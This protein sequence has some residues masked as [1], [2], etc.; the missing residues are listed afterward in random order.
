MFLSILVPGP[1]NPKAKVDVFLQPL[2]DELNHLWAYGVQ[3]Y[4]TSKKQN[5]QMRAV[6]LWTIN[7]FPAYSM[8]SGWRTMGQKTCPY[9]GEDSDA[10]YLP[11]SGKQSWFDNHRKFLP[12]DHPYHRSRYGFKKGET[13]TKYFRGVRSGDEILEELNQYGLKKV[14]EV[15]AERINGYIFKELWLV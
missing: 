10:F 4:D 12:L 6:L 14:T 7:D 8:L 2:I 5:F 3:T 15:D 1:N 13:V 11:V 9:Y